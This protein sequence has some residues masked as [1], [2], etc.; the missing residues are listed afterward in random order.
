MSDI[1]AVIEATYHNIRNVHGRGVI[2]LT[3]EM[4][5]EAWE[6]ANRVLGPPKSTEWFAIARLAGKSADAP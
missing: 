1:P 3:F 2:Q 5:I 6:H 4:P